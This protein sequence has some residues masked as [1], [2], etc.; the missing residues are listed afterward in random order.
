[1]VSGLCLRPG[2]PGACG[3]W[4]DAQGVAHA[5]REAPV[6]VPGDGDVVHAEAE[7]VVVWVRRHGGAE[8]VDVDVDVAA[9]AIGGADELH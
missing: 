3:A 1:M 8:G 2:A 5:G 6:V 7:D 4:G 9:V